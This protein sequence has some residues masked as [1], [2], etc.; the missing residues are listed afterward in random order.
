MLLSWYRVQDTSNTITW[1]FNEG[2]PSPLTIVLR[3]ADP[4]ILNGV[5]LAIASSVDT[6]AEVILECSCT[7]KTFN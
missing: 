1:T 5:G 2:D 6:F 3:N 7:H 4:R